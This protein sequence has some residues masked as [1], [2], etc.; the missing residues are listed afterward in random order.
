MGDQPSILA[1][2]CNLQ[3]STPLPPGPPQP[4]PELSIYRDCTVALLHRFFRLSVEVGR[5][6]SLL[7]REIF[8]GRSS[9]YRAHT[10]EDAVI[11][12]HDVERCLEQLDDLSRQVIAC[13]VLQDYSIEEAAALL[14]R[15]RETVMRRLPEALDLLTE[16][17]LRAGLLRPLVRPE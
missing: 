16:S 15:R 9:R 17:L 5:L 8:P 4:A 7:G 2:S 13:I 12:V 6:P 3:A 11:F 1:S 14:R 10:F